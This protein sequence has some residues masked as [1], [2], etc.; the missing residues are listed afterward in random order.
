[1]LALVRER[2]LVERLE[3]D[4]H[5]LLEQLA[6]GLLVEHGRPEGLDLSGVVAAP[7]AE[8]HAPV[9]QPV[10]GRI[11]LGHADGMPHRRD[12]EAAA[13][14]DV[15]GDV[16]EVEGQHEHVG[17][18]LVP[19]ALEVVL[20]QPEG[21][22]ARAV[23]ELGNGLALG[24]H[25]GQVLVGEPAIVRRRAVQPLVVQIDVAREQAAKPRDHDEIPPASGV[26]CG[27]IMPALRRIGSP[28]CVSMSTG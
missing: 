16:A 3:D 23:H 10:G 19:L 7:H 13:N 11:V 24:K 25:R 9:G 26:A 21:I 8:D 18:A 6:V 5:L 12:V 4:F 22:V 20:G 14:A 28:G 15:L 27:P 17:D 2:P 1:V